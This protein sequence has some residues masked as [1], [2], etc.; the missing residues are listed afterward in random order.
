MVKKGDNSQDTSYA[1]VGVKGETQIN[2]E[3]TGYGQFE[4]DPGSIKQTQPWTKLVLAYAG[5]NYK[6]FW[7]IRLR[8]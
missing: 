4:L 8:S 7:F 3:L 2:P 5:L 1:R 6:D